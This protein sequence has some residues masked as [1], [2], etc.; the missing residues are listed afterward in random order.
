MVNVTGYKLREA[1]R[2]WQLKRETAAVQ[3]PGTLLVFPGEEKPTPEAIAIAVV[4]AETRIAAIQTAQ[5]IYNTRVLVGFEGR[6]ITLLE[7][8]KL[9]GALGRVEKLWRV[10]AT[11]KKDKYA[12]YRSDDPGRLKEGEILA[13]RALTHEQ[14]AAHV[15]AI[16]ARLGVLRET[17]AVAN[18][19][20]MT[21][22]AEDLDPSL[23]E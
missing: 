10:A 13:K 9:V 18:A 14:A 21:L 8:I 2:K 17:I 6:T 5:T 16:A 4:E 20:R 1:L 15:E 11:G 3:F 7:A 19:N 12:H 23:L 22:L